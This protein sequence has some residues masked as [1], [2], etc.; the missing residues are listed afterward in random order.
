MA[1][2]RKLLITTDFSD[3]ATKGVQEGVRLATE[4]GCEALLLFVVEDRLPP[5]LIGSSNSWRDILEQHRKTATA[6]LSEYAA[7]HA[8]GCSCEIDVRIGVPSDVIVATA[9]E[10]EAD[11]IVMAPRGHGLVGHLVLGSTTERVIKKASCSVLVACSE[12]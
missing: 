3:E 11:L 8:A 2:Y 7:Q 5:M 1:I 12:D 9:A 4:L 10:V 6:S